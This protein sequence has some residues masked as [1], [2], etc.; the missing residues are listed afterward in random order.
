M[1]H[2]LTLL[3]CLACLQALPSLAQIYR[4]T[5][6]NGQVHFTDNPSAIPANR[7]DTSRE[8]S[9]RSSRPPGST[10]GTTR[11]PAAAQSSTPKSRSQAALNEESDRLR[12]RE[13]ALEQQIATL[14]QEQQRYLEQI[15]A[16]RGVRTNPAF[17]RQ[18]RRVGELGQALGAVERQLDTLRE[19]R[20]QVRTQRQALERGPSPAS[21]GPPASPAAVFDHL[22]RTRAYWQRR[23][24]A[25]RT[26]LQ[27]ARAQRQTILA[28]LAPTSDEEKRT[29]GRRGRQVL[30]LTQALEGAE[31]ERRDAETALEALRREATQAGAP[32]K[33]IQ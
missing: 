20:Q 15:A 13:Q 8:R 17:G 5:D 11:P 33:W 24:K 3:V 16:V 31:Q 1:R 18:R 32:A 4:W 29:F 6:E 21:S 30:Q 19:A 7:L 26:R 2:S 27:N 25:A 9:S 12:Q 10:A 28:Q 23:A 14:R 22:G